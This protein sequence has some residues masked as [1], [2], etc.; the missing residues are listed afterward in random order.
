MSLCL[1][2]YV[3]SLVSKSLYHAGGN[4]LEQSE[5]DDVRLW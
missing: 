1:T 3:L 2:A 4:A 5:V